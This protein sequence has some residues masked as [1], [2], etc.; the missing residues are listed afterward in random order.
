MKQSVIT[1]YVDRVYSGETRM[2]LQDYLQSIIE[3]NNDILQVIPT[4]Y[5]NNSIGTNQL[6]VA[7]II[8]K[9]TTTP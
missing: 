6:T 3:Q 7:T 9:Q 8:Y 1:W 2:N 4:K 5:A